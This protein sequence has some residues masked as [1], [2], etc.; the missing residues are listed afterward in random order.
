MILLGIALAGV[1]VSLLF[2]IVHNNLTSA[3]CRYRDTLHAE[4]E[5]K[6]AEM[7]VFI[8]LSSL[9]PVVIVLSGSLGLSLWIMSDSVA[10]SVGLASCLLAI[11]RLALAKARKN[12]LRKLDRQLPDTLRMLASALGSGASLSS[13]LN[14]IASDLSPP[15]SQELSLIMREQRVGIQLQ[16]ALDNF[17]ARADTDS[18]GQVTTLLR[19]GAKSGGSFAGLLD[20]LAGNLAAQQHIS[21]KV[22]MLTAQAR[23]QARVIGVL[24]FLLLIALCWMDMETM[25]IAFVSDVGKGLLT[26][27]LLLELV[28]IFWLRSILRKVTT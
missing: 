4:A 21:S 6:L 9:W 26:M 13:A 2:W 14:T 5:T 18:V 3:W 11:P 25:R 16:T 15:L 22:D 27:I 12:R 17:R 24:P 28:G 10:L 7:F 8:D 1:S 20:Q 19:V 23:V